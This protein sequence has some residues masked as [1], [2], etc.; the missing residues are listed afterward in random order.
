LSNINIG[1]QLS[2]FQMPFK[3]ALIAANRLGVR[4]VEIDARIDLDMEQMSASAIRQIRKMLDD[5]NLR[6]AAIRFRTRRGYDCREGLDRRVSAT[7]QA[8][9]LAFDM[10]ASVVVNQIG[11]VMA[12]LSGDSMTVLRD[13]LMDIGQ[14]GQRVGAFLAC[15]SGSEDLADLVAF[16]ESLPDGSAG[17]AL[18]PGNLLVNGFDLTALKSAARHVMLVHAKDGVKDLARGRGSEVPLGR[19]LAEFPEIIAT[20]AEHQFRGFYV[21][22]REISQNPF[23][24]I[25]QAVEFL[26]NVG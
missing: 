5:L 19:G 13:A 11:Q 4:G 14:H 21:V 26:K 16:I 17:I 20:L 25:S 6:V 24:E 9:R 8:M 23:E 10:G 7:K 2:S 1:V 12:D 18:N 22:E 15:E 3:N